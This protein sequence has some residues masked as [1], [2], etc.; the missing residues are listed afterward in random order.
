MCLR[1]R[2]RNSS[3]EA[4]DRRLVNVVH[5]YT[6]LGTA[7]EGLDERLELLCSRNRC[8]CAKVH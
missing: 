8:V 5:Q 3:S 4:N 7:V 6:A 2:L 1:E